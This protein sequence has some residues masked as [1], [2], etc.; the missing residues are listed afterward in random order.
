VKYREQALYD[1]EN[2]LKMNPIQFAY[3]SWQP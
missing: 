2:P 1:E 3:M